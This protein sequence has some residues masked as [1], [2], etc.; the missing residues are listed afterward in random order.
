M[1]SRF[2]PGDLVA[3]SYPLARGLHVRLR[4]AR[5]RDAPGIEALLE[6]L[7]LRAQELELARLVRFDPRCRIVICATTLIGSRE[8]VAGFGAIA[9][10]AAEPEL[11]LVDE[12]LTAGLGE[13]LARAL[14]GRA[15]AVARI[16]A[17]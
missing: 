14:I 3:H 13:L 11:L 12:Q 15:R 9:L 2:D 1:D 16:R 4:L 17:A 5:P 6:R 10:E 8:V 7:G